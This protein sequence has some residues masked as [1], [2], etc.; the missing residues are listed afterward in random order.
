MVPDKQST[1]HRAMLCCSL[2]LEAQSIPQTQGSHRA[3]VL[4]RQE[5]YCFRPQ[6][7]LLAPKIVLYSPGTEKERR[8][9]SLSLSNVHTKNQLTHGGCILLF[10]DSCLCGDNLKSPEKPVLKLLS[11]LSRAGLTLRPCLPNSE[12]CLASVWTQSTKGR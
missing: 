5:G 2:L 8:K 6:D 7:T 4:W 9:P 12:F 10:K 3:L 11:L 1:F